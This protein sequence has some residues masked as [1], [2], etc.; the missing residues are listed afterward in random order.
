MSTTSRDWYAW[1]DVTPPP[2]LHV[3]GDVLVGNPGVEALLTMKE[4]Q[5]G[6]PALLLLDLHLTQKPGMWPQVKTWIQARYDRTLPPVG[7]RYVGVQ[8]LLNDS[9]LARMSVH[10][11]Q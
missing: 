4:P 10:S 6:D 5:G 3:V 7:A 8:V 11:I 1:I 2:N 9:Q